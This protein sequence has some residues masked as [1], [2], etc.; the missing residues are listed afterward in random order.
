MLPAVLTPDAIDRDATPAEAAR[1]WDVD[2]ATLDH[3]SDG[4]SFTYRCRLDGADHF[5]RLT[6]VRWRT[7]GEVAAELAFIDRAGRFGVVTPVI[8]PSRGGRLIE[9]VETPATTV[10]AVV[11]TALDG[12]AGHAIVVDSAF[13][14]AYGATLARLHR[15]GEG[16]HPWAAHAR[17]WENDAAL[18]RSWLPGTQPELREALDEVEAWMRTLPTPPHE[19][20]LIHSDLDLSNLAWDGRRLGVFD[21]G[22]TVWG[23]FAQELDAGL[24]LFGD[25]RAL[26]DLVLAA[27]RSERPFPARWDQW[28]PMFRRRLAL[29]ALAWRFRAGPAL[30]PIPAEEERALRAAAIGPGPR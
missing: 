17:G 4:A 8:R 28:R 6:D 2:P 7:P 5:L 22:D 13:A 26:T 19:F 15:A 27:Y 20:G 30:A 18:I 11:F 9:A 16:H 25:D 29:G 21:F 14:R 24:T 12:V 1:R 3:V 10:L 23:W